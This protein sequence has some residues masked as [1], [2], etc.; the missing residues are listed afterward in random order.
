[1]INFLKNIYR[2]FKRFSIASKY[3]N[4]KYLQIFNW[5][6]NSKEDSNFTYS[7]NKTNLEYLAHTISIVTGS[8]FDICFKYLQEPYKNL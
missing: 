4:F 6:F 3:Y 7:L 1:M 5:L 2:K 8:D